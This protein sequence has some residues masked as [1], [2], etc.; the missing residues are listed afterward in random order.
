MDKLEQYLV[1]NVLVVPVEVISNEQTILDQEETKALANEVQE[2]RKQILAERY[3]QKAFEEEE[4]RLDQE[5]QLLED[6]QEEVNS[7]SN[8]IQEAQLDG[9]LHE[10]VQTIVDNNVDIKENLIQLAKYNV[11][12]GQHVLPDA[13]S[14]FESRKLAVKGNVKGSRFGKK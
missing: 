12:E 1:R 14:V 13:E 3:M 8:A 2:L 9:A 6:H 11:K 4:T 10:K 5:F 7:L